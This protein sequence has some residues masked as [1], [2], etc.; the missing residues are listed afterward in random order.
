M[1]NILIYLYKSNLKPVGGHHGYNYN[2]NC[3]LE[4]MGVS[5]IHFIEI[6]KGNYEGYKTGIGDVKI[7]WIKTLLLII[8]NFVR[9]GMLLWGGSHKAVVDLNQ[10][11]IVHFQSTYWMYACRDSLKVFKG[12]VVLTSHSPTLLSNEII[13]GLTSFEKKHMM[14]YY[15]HLIKMDEYA[16]NRADYI[17]FP[18]EE[19]EEP[20]YHAWDKFKELK[21]QYPNKFRYL[22]S[23]I[24]PCHAKMTNKEV[25]R[26][27]DIP[28]DA[29]VICYV[30]RHNEIKGYDLLKR[31]GEKLLESSNAYVLVAGKEE[32]LKGLSHKRWIEVGWTDD[33]HSLIAASDVFVLPNKETYFDLVMLEVLSLGK[34]VVA[35]KTGGNKYFERFPNCGIKLFDSTEECIDILNKLSKMEV[36]HRNGLGIMN[37]RIY[38]EYFTSASFANNYQKLINS[39]NNNP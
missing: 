31:V 1:K 10:Y 3:Q 23:G 14:W 33:P 35:N 39:L 16:F 37:Q 2:L 17:F 29:F 12:T 15:K 5:N 18:C 32:P 13:D 9:K 26:M 28:E 20:Y 36:K 24:E 25:R 6:E 30:G 7:K 27:Y 21:R 19:A 11:D 38:E 22:L 34:V 8:K 4:K